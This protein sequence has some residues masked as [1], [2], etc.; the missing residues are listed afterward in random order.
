MNFQLPIHIAEPKSKIGYRDKLMLIGSCFTEH[1]GKNLSSL[2]F[3]IL[4]NPNGILFDPASVANA[5]ISYVDNIQLSEDDL[6]LQDEICQLA[7]H[8]AGYF[9]FLSTVAF[10]DAGCQLSSCTGE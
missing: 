10:T 5:I 7:Y 6:F 1:I 9:F 3:D 2:K 4:Q 8:Y